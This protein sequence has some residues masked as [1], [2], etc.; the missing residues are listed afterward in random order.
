MWYKTLSFKAS[1][2]DILK[3]LLK[4]QSEFHTFFIRQVLIAVLLHKNQH[5][6]WKQQFEAKY[7]TYLDPGANQ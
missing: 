4:L 2:L 7:Y 3:F 5:I 6:F 1:N